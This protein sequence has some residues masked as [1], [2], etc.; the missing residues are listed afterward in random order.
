MPWRRLL[1]ELRSIC[2]FG[3]GSRAA[4]S[5]L[6]TLAACLSS[7]APPGAVLIAT[8]TRDLVGGLFRYKQ[9]GPVTVAEIPEPVAAWLV[10]GEGAVESR[11]DALRASGLSPMVGRQE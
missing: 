11:F 4:W 6:A 1:P 3:S 5:S 7:L 9:I 10:V 2:A 8:S